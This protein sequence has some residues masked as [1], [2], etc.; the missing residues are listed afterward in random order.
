[1]VGRFGRIVAPPDAASELSPLSGKTG[2]LAVAL[3]DYAGFEPVQR[4]VAGAVFDG[5]SRSIL[6]W[7]LRSLVCKRLTLSRSRRQ[8]TRVPWTM[9][10]TRPCSSINGMSRSASRSTS[11]RPSVSSNGSW[12]TRCWSAGGNARASREKLRAART[13]RDEVVGSTARD[14]V[15]AEI[16]RLAERDEALER[17]IRRSIR[18][19]TRSTGNGETS[20]TSSGTGRHT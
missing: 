18:G 7:R 16:L 15:E 8:W 4:L 1:M 9:Q 14:R 6:R 12:T 19:K 10:W 2:V 5:T 11:S 17:R 13:R 20:I 3:A